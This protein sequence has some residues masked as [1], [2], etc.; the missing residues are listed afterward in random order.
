MSAPAPGSRERTVLLLSMPGLWPHWPFLPL[1]RRTR[2]IEELGVVF[3]ARAAGLTGYS[4]TVLKCNLFLLPPD[5][6]TFLALPKEVF[7]SVEELADAQWR[8]D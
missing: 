1:V 3:D 2:G 5:F 7:D 4:A 8:V 6:D